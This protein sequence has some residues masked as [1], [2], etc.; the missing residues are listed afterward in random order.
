MTN[1]ATRPHTEL[2]CTVMWFRNVDV[3]TPLYILA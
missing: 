3:D 1:I 2:T